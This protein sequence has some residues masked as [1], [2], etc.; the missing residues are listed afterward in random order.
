MDLNPFCFRITRVSRGNG[1][2]TSRTRNVKFSPNTHTLS[3]S[4]PDELDRLREQKAPHDWPLAQKA[5]DPD[6]TM[7]DSFPNQNSLSSVF[8]HAP[9]SKI[10]PEGNTLPEGKE[11]GRAG[12]G[13]RLTVFY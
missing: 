11:Q 7:P 1:T 2:L 13:Q 3:L 9:C 10:D 4:L 8:N 6:E 12:Q 5:V